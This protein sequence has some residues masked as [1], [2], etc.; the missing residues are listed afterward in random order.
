VGIGRT[1][2]PFQEHY[3]LPELVDFWMVIMLPSDIPRIL[4]ALKS[5]LRA[6]NL[7]YKKLAARLLVHETTVK[8]NLNGR[9]LSLEFLERICNLADL[10]MSELLELAQDGEDS[11]H[12]HISIRQESGLASN[13][14]STFFLLLLQRKWTPDDIR[15][16][17]RLSEAQLVHHLVRLDRLGV[18]KLLPNNRVRVLIGRHPDWKSG[19]PMRQTFNR[20]LGQQFANMDYPRGMF[21]VETVK[22]APSSLALVQSLMKDFSEAIIR[23]GER[24][25]QL[26]GERQDWYS[27]LVAARPVDPRSIPDGD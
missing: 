20:W 18:I 21:E 17:F 10:R 22:I 6:K 8:R 26:R 15:E 25:H 7:T 3:V 4:A 16:E 23:I 27:I 24:D 5:A 14:L 12:H 19:G 13:L 1:K 2:R 9:G 11:R